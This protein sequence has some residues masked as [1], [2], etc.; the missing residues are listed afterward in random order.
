MRRRRARVLAGLA[1]VGV[2]ACSGPLAVPTEV[3]ATVPI[4][5]PGTS[6]PPPTVFAAAS[7]AAPF[8]ELA[9]TTETE[10][11]FSFDGSSG[12][13]DQLLGGAAA[14]VFAAADTATMERAVA[15]GLAQSDPVRFAT[16]VLVLITPVDDPA[17]VTGLNESLDGAKLV[18]C[19]PEVPCGRATAELADRLGVDL[20]P[21]SEEASV[22]DVLGK[23]TSGEADAGLVYSTDAVRAA[24]EVR[25]VEI[26]EALE[27]PN[28]Y[29]IVPV[30]GGSA[31]SA[32][33]FIEL[34]TSPEGLELLAAQGFG[35]P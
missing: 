5:V 16:N 18:T 25:T 27:E 21:V 31:E 20:E 7:L 34:V 15:E 26:P 17:G 29:W 6:E 14:D 23:V 8:E 13:V 11:Q 35:P 1:L 2:T 4:V 9:A 24:A 22:T 19:A 33:E 30:S 32:A 12:L 10:V 3:P 28:E